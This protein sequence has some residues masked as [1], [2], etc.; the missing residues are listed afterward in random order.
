MGRRPAP[1]AVPS[2]TVRQPVVGQSWRYA[3]HD[4]FTGAVVDTQDDVVAAVGSTI[5]IH[6]STES[7]IVDRQPTS[8]NKNW[9]RRYFEHSRPGGALPSEVQG[10]WGVIMVDPHWSQVQ[11]YD[12]PIPLWP[13]TL[14]P[15]WHAHIVTKYRT[16]DEAGLPWEQ[17]MK[18]E[19]WE[20]LTVPAGSFRVLR[21]SNHINFTSS[22]LSRSNSVRNETLWFAPE[23]GRWV[24]RESRGTYYF[25]ES[26]ADD[27][28][29]ESSYR[30]E[31]LRYT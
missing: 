12:Q 27:Q 28:N 10:P 22:D 21:Y 13:S 30:W 14:D 5:D 31:L 8:A 6:S 4:L 19:A 17:T 24:A 16:S 15:G 29:N 11:I 20:N 2:P 7:D 18:A 1:P 9:L 26:V 25:D 3:K 23:V